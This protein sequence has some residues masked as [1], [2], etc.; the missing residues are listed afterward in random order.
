M[1]KQLML[2]SA[3]L[4]L[5]LGIVSGASAKTVEFT[6]SDGIQPTESFETL[7]TPTLY[8]FFGSSSFGFFLITGTDV[9]IGGSS[10]PNQLYGFSTTTEL[11]DGPTYYDLSGPIMIGPSVAL[12][13]NWYSGPITS[14]TFIE[15]TYLAYNNVDGQVATVTVATV[16]AVPEPSTWAMMLIGFAGIGFA[17]YRGGKSITAPIATA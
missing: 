3:S 8:G 17:A 5:S 9:K 13:V 15:G 14:P 2:T 10:A 6:L 11:N 12:G 7:I 1:I 16:S 4:L